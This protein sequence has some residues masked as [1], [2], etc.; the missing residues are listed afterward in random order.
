MLNP[1]LL[2]LTLVTFHFVH[3]GKKRKKIM[4]LMRSLLLW[5]SR[6]E[7]LRRML[8]RFRFVRSAVTRFMPG[9][10]IDDALGAAQSLREQGIPT[11]VTHLGENLTHEHEAHTVADHYLDVLDRIKTRGLDCHVSVKLTQL[12]FDL[13]DELCASLMEKIIRRAKELGNMVWIDME[14][15]PYVDRT[16]RLFKQMRTKYDN[17][18]VCLQSYLIRTEADLNALLSVVPSIRL[19][20]GAYAELA[21]VVF[22]TKRETDENFFR[23]SM[24]L[25]HAA[26]TNGAAIGIGTHDITLVERIQS[27]AVKEGITKNSYEV[28]MLYGIRR[29]EQR[30]LV[31]E[32]FRVR[33]LISYGSFWFPWYMRRLAE[34]PANVWFVLKSMVVR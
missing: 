13:S 1:F 15:S 28:Q 31:K 11:I 26:R 22:P 10:E 16:L 2:C 4:G 12:G 24:K 18:G 14:N 17:V 7:M 23:L 5:S 19:V 9:E 29:E 20:K 25:L 32:G 33:V 21:G 3:S 27:A 8:P 30:R 6:N 34:R